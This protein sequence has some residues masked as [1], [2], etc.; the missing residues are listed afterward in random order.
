[1]PPALC[2]PSAS[3]APPSAQPGSPCSSGPPV[4]LLRMPR[5]SLVPRLVIAHSQ[6]CRGVMRREGREEHA[7]KTSVHSRDRKHPFPTF[8]GQRDGFSLRGSGALTV[9][10]QPHCDTAQLRD[11]GSPPGTS[12]RKQTEIERETL[13][14]FLRTHYFTGGLFS[15][16]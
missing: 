4:S 11:L 3:V 8:S 10:P 13:E 16:L 14:V 1:M 5:A 6:G 9:H 15:V 2:F 12:R 7:T